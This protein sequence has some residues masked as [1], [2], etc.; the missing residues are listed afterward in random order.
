MQNLRQKL[1]ITMFESLYHQGYHALNLNAVLKEAGTSKGGMY[2]Y[3]PSKKALALESIETVLGSY[4]QNVWVTPL[5]KSE[6]P[7]QTLYDTIRRLSQM[8]LVDNIYLEFHYGCPINNL[9]QELSAQ[10]EAFSTLLRALYDRW[11]ESII[12]ALMRIKKELRID[13]DIEHSAAFIVAS[14]EGAFSYAKVYDSKEDF[15]LLMQQLVEFIKSLVR[16]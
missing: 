15:D 1:L 5:Q 11:K 9:I 4:I 8:P 7:L 10:D 16:Y 3:F 6:N 2:H 14:I 12:K 13:V